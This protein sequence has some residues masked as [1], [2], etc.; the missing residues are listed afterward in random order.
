MN[1]LA[2]PG[3]IRCS[4]TPITD[5]TDVPEPQTADTEKMIDVLDNLRDQVLSGEITSF[6]AVGIR[7]DN[8]TAMWAASAGDAQPLQLLG[9]ITIMQQKF[10]NA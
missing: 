9:A 3:S 8:S 1:T 4:M 2:S 5:I 7:P 10:I 6:A